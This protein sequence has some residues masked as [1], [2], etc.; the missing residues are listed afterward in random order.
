MQ[1]RYTDLFHRLISTGIFAL[2]L[3][4]AASI[5]DAF[6]AAA[7]LVPFF[8]IYI[9]AQS[10]HFLTYVVLARVYAVGLE[11]AINELLEGDVLIAHRLEA[12]YLFPLGEP[13]FAGV[14]LRADQ[15]YNGFITIHFWVLGAVAFALASYRAWQLL[16]ALETQFSPL[17][18][19]FPALIAWSLL[20]LVYLF[21]YFG[22]RYHEQRVRRIVS[23]AYDTSYEN[24]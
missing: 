8:V 13:Q 20:H 5:T 16:P 19:Y 9:G 24:A 1:H 10:A 14:P 23:D 6:R 15:T 12:S 18:F 17:A 4:A 11:K 2:I 22:T 7:L 3:L 21:W